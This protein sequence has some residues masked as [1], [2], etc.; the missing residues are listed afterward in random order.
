M[1]VDKKR[2]KKGNIVMKKLF[3]LLLVFAVVGT[4]AGCRKAKSETD[5]GGDDAGQENTVQT[6]IK[7]EDYE[8][9]TII[10]GQ[11]LE[12]GETYS[13]KRLW[14]DA[15]YRSAKSAVVSV[16]QKG[17]ITAKE[18]GTTLVMAKSEKE[19]RTSAV[20]ITVLPSG[21][22]LD[23]KAAGPQVHQVN[24]AYKLQPSIPATAF[25]SSNDAIAVVSENGLLQFKSPGYVTV[26]A[27]GS[28]VTEIYSFIVYDRAVEK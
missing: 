8:T 22:S 24:S 19:D 5:S 4:A 27:S 7:D 1:H 15:E 2:D 9:V 14:E 18:A 12:I 25:Q 16:D 6:S 28:G 23:P 21:S 3:A 10:N 13:F 17:T 11:V 20:V 26:T